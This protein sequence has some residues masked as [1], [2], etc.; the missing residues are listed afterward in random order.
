MRRAIDREGWLLGGALVAVVVAISIHLEGAPRAI[1]V[2]L[3][4]V[5]VACVIGYFFVRW[6]R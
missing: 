6:R 5:S 4:V 3:L 2:P 1:V